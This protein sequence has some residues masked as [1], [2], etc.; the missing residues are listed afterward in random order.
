MKKILLAL[1]FSL[2][3]LFAGTTE[4]KL[5]DTAFMDITVGDE[6]NYQYVKHYGQGFKIKSR[7]LNKVYNLFERRDIKKTK[8]I[9]NGRLELPRDV[10]SEIYLRIK[11]APT[12]AWQ[13]YGPKGNYNSTLSSYNSSGNRGYGWQLF[14]N[15]KTVMKERNKFKVSEDV[16]GNKFLEFR[17]EGLAWNETFSANL[18]HMLDGMSALSFSAEMA[19]RQRKRGEA[20]TI[21]QVPLRV[22]VVEE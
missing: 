11:G 12:N 15:S 16:L 13:Y 9:I 17:I 22:Y 3:T 20:I 4:G 19:T 2:T 1:L 21:T 5:L 6:I 18:N 14:V 8:V 7:S 10:S